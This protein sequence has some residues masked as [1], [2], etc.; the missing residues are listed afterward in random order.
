MLSKQE[1]NVKLSAIA[2]ISKDNLQK[3]ITEKCNKIEAGI[4]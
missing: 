2:S 3:F 4:A 1:I